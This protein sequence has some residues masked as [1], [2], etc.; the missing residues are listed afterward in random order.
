MISLCI[1]TFFLYAA[2]KHWMIIHELTAT[3]IFR[4]LPYYYIGYVMGQAH[5]LKDNQQGRNIAFCI[6][7]FAISLFLFYLHLHEER[8][9]IHVALFY[10]VNIGFLVG[11]I[12]G[13]KLLNQFKSDIIINLSVG[14][15]VIIGFH[16]VIIG[17]INYGIKHLFLPGTE[18]C[19]HWYSAI[20]TS[21]FIVAIL[22][23]VIIFGK[24]YAPVLLGR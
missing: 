24:K 11:V 16:F 9:L 2:D 1:V 18:I 13:C 15:L 7:G 8:L 12:Y 21:L 19:Y 14:T 3:G 4:R 20:P 6:T 5:L 10:P 23:P 22:Y 17:A